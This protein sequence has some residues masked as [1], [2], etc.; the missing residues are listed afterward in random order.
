MSKPSPHFHI[1]VIAISC[2]VVWLVVYFTM[3]PSV[4][5]LYL[6][7]GAV[8]NFIISPVVISLILIPAYLLVILLS[9]TSRRFQKL[10]ASYYSSYWKRVLLVFLLVLPVIVGMAIITYIPIYTLPS[11][12]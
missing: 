5:Q 10:L 4:N 9:F 12:I 6:D 7:L 3:L 8:P 11:L 1:S 2:L